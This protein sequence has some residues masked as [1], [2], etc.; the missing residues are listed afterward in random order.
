M[1]IPNSIRKADKAVLVL[2]CLVGLLSIACIAVYIFKFVLP[3]DNYFHRLLS[4]SAA[5]TQATEKITEATTTT[6]A[7]TATTAPPEKP[8]DLL[9]AHLRKADS[10]AY[11]TGFVRKVIEGEEKMPEGKKVAFITIDDGVTTDHTPQMLDTLK[12]IDVPATFYILGQSVGEAT[13]P[14]LQRILD[15]GH[16]IGL[17]SYNHD[18]ELLYPGRNADTSEIMQQLKD[19]E[20][21]I[22][23]QLGPDFFSGTWR[24]PGG[25]MSWNYLEEADAE[26]A[27]YGVDWIDWNCLFGDA[28]PEDVRPTNREEVINFFKSSYNVVSGNSCVV[29]LLHDNMYLDHS[30]EALPEIAEYLRSEGYEF[31]ILK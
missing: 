15:E 16:S 17:H 27:N 13:K 18:Y 6:T 11:D 22:K 9:G 19:S 30:R 10:Y 8:D 31:G 21:A 7:T 5:T 2:L 28:E 29:I 3:Q 1:S 14:V 12:E 20:A 26:M 23:E 24:Y 4:A 25:H